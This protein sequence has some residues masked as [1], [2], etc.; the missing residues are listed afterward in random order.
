MSTNTRL[1]I[2]MDKKLRTSLKQRADELGFDS[3]Q[4]LLRYITKAIIEGR[5]VTFGEPYDDWG[6]PSPSA[7]ARLDKISEEGRGDHAAGKLKTYTTAE[8]ALKHLHNL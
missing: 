3:S 4:A 8:E 1:T 7:V 5:Q 6:K 2:P